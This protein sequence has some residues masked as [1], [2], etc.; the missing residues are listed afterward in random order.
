MSAFNEAIAWAKRI[1]AVMILL[2]IGMTMLDLLGLS[3][4]GLPSLSAD[5]GTGIFLA[6][7]G[8]LWSKL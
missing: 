6:G 8:F 3:V 2:L 4:R 7:L 5:Q 1:I